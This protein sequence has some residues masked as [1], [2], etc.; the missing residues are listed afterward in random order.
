MNTQKAGRTSKAKA[1]KLLTK[2]EMFFFEY[3]GYNYDPK[4]ETAQQG[5]IRCARAM[6]HAE[7]TATNMGWRF[8]WDYDT[9]NYERS[10]GDHEYWCKDAKNGIEHEH[11]ILWCQCQDKDGDVLASLGAIIDPS[12]SYRRVVEA[13]LA[14]EAESELDREIETIDAH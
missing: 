13:E 12:T 3:G 7:Q 2:D 9:D 1:S 14:L 6:A 4:T 10:L 11:E 8:E 5:R